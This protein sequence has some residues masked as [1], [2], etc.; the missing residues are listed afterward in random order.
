MTYA[1]EA[2][3]FTLAGSWAVRVLAAIVVDNHRRGMAAVHRG[4]SWDPR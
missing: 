3:A 1:V 2:L 4:R